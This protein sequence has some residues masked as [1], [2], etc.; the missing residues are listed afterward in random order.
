MPDVEL[1]GITVP[2][3]PQKHAYLSHRIG[4]AVQ[5]VIDSGEG[6]TADNLLA[7]IGDGVYDI[8]CALIPS[9]PSRIPAHV[10]AGYETAEAQA[11]GDFNEDKAATLQG[12]PTILEIKVA[13]TTALHVNGIDELVNL[14]KGI[15]DL[16]LL[17]AMA[18]Q[19][20]AEY[21]EGPTETTSDSPTLPSTSGEPVS[22]SS[23]TDPPTPTLMDLSASLSSA[24]T[25]S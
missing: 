4:P 10:F 2:V 3:V 9:I 25:D 6:V 16:R 21:L 19:K 15:V 20:I 5:N 13:L 17:R 23:T 18:N 1:G 24:S 22:T 11:A 14:G 7:W 8:L 12:C